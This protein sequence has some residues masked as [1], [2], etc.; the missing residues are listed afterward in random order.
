MRAIDLTMPLHP[1][2]PV[3]PTSGPFAAHPES[4]LE[5]DGFLT[6][7]LDL[8]E[9]TGTHLDAPRHF[10]R[11]GADPAGITVDRLVVPA[12]VFD[13]AARAEADPD[14][15]LLPDDITAHEAEHGTVPSGSAALVRTGWDRWVDDPERYVRAMRFPGVSVDAG[16]LLVQR[17]VVGLGIDAPGV[18]PG[19]AGDFPLHAHVTLPAGLWHL[20]GLVGLHALPPVGALLVVGA[21]PVVGGSGAPA[22]VLALLP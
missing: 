11:T 6:R 1:G 7:R 5:R 9:H 20:E 4:S 16:R 18:D 15:V 21:L 17:G 8:S 12:V 10:H 19:V 13:I 2:T 3:W 14:A 22:R